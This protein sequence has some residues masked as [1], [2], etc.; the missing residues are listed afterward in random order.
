MNYLAHLFLSGSNEEIIIGNFIGDYVK[1]H[2]FMEFPENIRKG[3]TLH[4]NIDMFTD[5]NAIVRAS[6]SRFSSHY[7]KY[8]GVVIDIFYDHFLTRHWR[9]FSKVNINVFARRIYDILKRNFKIL[10][11]E[12]QLFIPSF[13]SNKWL[14]AYQSVLG[15][16]HVLRKMSKRTSLP[17]YTDF[18]I[19]VL[20]ADY[21]FLDEE[22]LSYFPKLIEFVKENFLIEV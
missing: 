10:P 17:D 5:T 19:Q 21:D 13:I 18:A 20:N 7:G 6:K 11:E 14:T 16:D 9:E 1:G 12:V 2:K 22:F 4:R 3:I 8:S 15:I